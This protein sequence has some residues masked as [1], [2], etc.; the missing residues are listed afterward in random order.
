MA[1]R[2]QTP[3]VT[4]RSTEEWIGRTPDSAIPVRVRRRVFYR[5]D[6]K[7]HLSGREIRPGDLWDCDHIVALVNG[8]EHREANLAPALRDKHREKTAEDVA[9][10][11]R[12]NRIR[13]R[14]LGI[15]RKSSRPMAGSRDSKWKQTINNGW[16]L[17]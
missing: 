15:K 5:Y 12:S 1:I 16:Q 6:G 14:Y 17:R 3:P 8:G 2:I 4:S 11:A 7:C 9:E 10:K 13:D